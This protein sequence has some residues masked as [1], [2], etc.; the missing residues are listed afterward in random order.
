MGTRHLRRGAVTVGRGTVGMR[1]A[2]PF[3]IA[4]M[5]AGP[6][7]HQIQESLAVVIPSPTGYAADNVRISAAIRLA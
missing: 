7:A 1:F 2:D 3:R 5:A 4:A 6:V